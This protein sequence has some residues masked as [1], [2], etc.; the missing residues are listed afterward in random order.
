M[1]PLDRLTNRPSFLLLLRL[2]TLH[3]QLHALLV[4]LQLL[5]DLLTVNMKVGIG[6]A[7]LRSWQDILNLGRLLRLCWF[8]WL[9]W[10]RE[11]LLH[12]CA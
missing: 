5:L 4:L 7:E 1:G 6:C 9:A 8:E 12:D 11:L 3:P 10:L 2:R